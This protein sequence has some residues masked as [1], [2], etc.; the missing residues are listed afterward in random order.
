METERRDLLPL[1]SVRDVSFTYREAL[2][3]ALRGVSFDLSP[4]ELLVVMGASGA[5]KSTLCRCLNGLIPHFLRGALTGKI[6]AVG[7]DTQHTRVA[8]CAQQ[9]GLVFQ[10]FEA[11]LFSTNVELEVAFGAESLGL[12]RRQIAERVWKLLALVGLTHLAAR[13]PASLSGGEKQR[14]AIAAALAADPPVLVLDEATSD[15]DPVGKAAVFKLARQLAGDAARRGV[16]FAHHDAEEAVGASRVLVLSHGQAVALDTPARVLSQPELLEANGVAPLAATSVLA[17][18]GLDERP[19]DEESAAER[20]LSRGLRIGEGTIGAWAERDRA[21]AAGYG[22][23]VIEAGGLGYAY[24][25]G[26]AAISGIDLTIQRGEFVA[27]IGQNGS[28]KT[29]LVKHFNGLLRPTS[30]EVLVGGEPTRGQSLRS[31][32]AE[33]G[34]VFQNPDNQIFAPTVLEEVAFGPRNFGL[35]DTE[36]RARVAESLA[37]VGLTGRE[38]EDPFSLTKGE[39]QRVAVASVLAGRPE[40]LIFDEPTTGLDDRESRAM[41][42]LIEQLNRRGHTVIVVTHAMWLAAEHAHRVVVMQEGRIVLDAPTRAAFSQID[43]LR[44]AAIIPPQVV[45]L[46]QLLGGTALTAPELIEALRG[47]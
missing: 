19:L 22:E 44:R 13:R 14:L 11:Q 17:A 30:G 39:R 35:D 45:R 8:E 24:S 5:G 16:V 36:A 32:A 41:M 40:V 42:A 25:G 1:L 29:T 7:R 27:V 46:S 34:Y 3:P 33:V 21:L 18:L 9:V 43:M 26:A 6:I 15:L 28:G 4:G 31:L 12:P 38:E 37:A 23:P 2:A 10:D 47:R 20:L